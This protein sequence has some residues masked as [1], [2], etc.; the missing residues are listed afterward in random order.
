MALLGAMIPL[1]AWAQKPQ[2]ALS[3][4]AYRSDSVVICG[5]I[6]NRT[7]RTAPS[8]AQNHFITDEPIE[9]SIPVDS[10][11]NF[12]VA[13]PVFG[14][15]RLYLYYVANG[16]A[17]SLFA[18]PG[19]K[20]TIEADWKE[21]RVSF[22]G[23]NARVHQEVF[24]YHSYQEKMDRRYVE[25]ARQENISHEQYLQEIKRFV[26]QQD[27]VLN[28]YLKQYPDIS[29]PSKRE[30]RIGNYNTFASALLQRRFSLDRMRG[31]KFSQAYMAYA[32]SVFAAL[33]Q[34]YTVAS[35]TFLRDYLDYYS[36]ARQTPAA[37]RMAVVDYAIKEK[38]IVPNE[39]QLKNR[40]LI[41]QVKEFQPILGAVFN[42][43]KQTEPF[44]IMMLDYYNGGALVVPMGA[45]LKEIVTTKAFYK[46]LNDHRMSLS[47]THI[48]YFKQ[49]VKNPTLQTFVLDY[50][51]RLSNLESS[52][53]NFAESLKDATSFKDCKSGEELFA[54]LVAPHRG[55]I[56][57]LD[58][59][60]TWCAPCKQEMKFAGAIKE[61]MKG[62]D[63]IFLYLANGSS[64][65]S[66]KNVI[67]ENHL[68]G[69]QVEHYNLPS[70]QQQ[71]VESYLGI[72][73]YP[74]Y[75]IIDK[76]GKVME[77]KSLR[78]SNGKQLVD[79]LNELIVK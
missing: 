56:V 20:I 2:S 25:F 60:G 58:V 3:S 16:S 75:M 31:E 8:V 12:R 7:V 18:E 62:K 68:T 70:A 10:L 33:P 35:T 44:V 37:F 38:R 78:P 64:E 47:G 14:T 1:F 65:V 6:L 49:Q 76:E 43:I 19:E 69:Q 46:Y 74:T 29:E 72:R 9:I 73:F 22:G 54:R 13:V 52:R 79:H 27:S 51:H 66:W 11:G 42:E 63:V 57:Y 4:D 39:E 36:E 59:W 71:M 34:P 28:A 77:K 5:H 24:D 61:A 45:E 30:I 40:A 41:F 15:T 26:N 32:D 48:D 50:Q 55:K 23:E 21:D 17:I 53:L 67:K